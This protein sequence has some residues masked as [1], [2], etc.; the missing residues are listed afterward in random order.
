MPISKE[1]LQPKYNSLKQC[2]LEKSFRANNPEWVEKE[3]ERSRERDKRR[4][5]SNE[6]FRQKKIQYAR[7]RRERLKKENPKLYK[8]KKAEYAKRSYEKMRKDPVRYEKWK[9]YHKNREK[10][11][12]ETNREKVNQASLESVRRKRST[13]SGRAMLNLKQRKR[14]ARSQLKKGKIVKGWKD[15]EIE[16]A[17][18]KYIPIA[19]STA[20][21]I[22]DNHLKHEDLKSFILKCCL[23]YTSPSPRDS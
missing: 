3:K 6:K 23:L 17:L 12:R 7:D 19:N 14:Y 16:E 5:W 13:D 9:E 8:E 1:L 4:W 20:F 21:K 10:I 11:R 2:Q 22:S 15:K 18:K